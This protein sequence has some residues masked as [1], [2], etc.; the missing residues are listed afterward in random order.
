M[1]DDVPKGGGNEVSAC[2][3]V[4]G[5]TTNILDIIYYN[6]NMEVLMFRTF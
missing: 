1:L 6:L 2:C 5:C 3:V 4:Y